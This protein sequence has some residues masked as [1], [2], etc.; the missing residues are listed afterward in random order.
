MHTSVLR[1]SITFASGLLL[2]FLAACAPRVPVVRPADSVASVNV[3]RLSE[4]E[5]ALARRITAKLNPVM[6]ERGRRGNR[7][8]ITF[9]EL[10]SHLDAEEVSFAREI[11]GMRPENVGVTTPYL[12]F[13]DTGVRLVRLEQCYTDNGSVKVEIPAQYLP[14]WVKIRYDAMMDAM[15]K[16]IGAR[17]YVESGYRSGAYQLYLFLDSLPNHGWSVRET[18]RF[19]AFPGYSEHGDTS[20]QAMDFVN[21][22]NVSEQPGE[23]EKLPEYTWLTKRAGCFGFALSYPPGS[24][25]GITFEPW[26]WHAEEHP[27]VSAE[28]CGDI[29][30]IKP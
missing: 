18:A 22:G 16:E 24:P 7:T 9:D 23:F 20:R 5:Q 10:F 30:A 17:L 21:I 1:W 26:H 6:D 11:R 25:T 8:I 29:N 27:P 4:R 14:E 15:Q 19:V 3:D 2:T 12:G 13:G 28:R